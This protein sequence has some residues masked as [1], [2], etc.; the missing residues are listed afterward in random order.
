MSS[1]AARLGLYRVLEAAGVGEIRSQLSEGGKGLGV[2]TGL[3]GPARSLAEAVLAADEQTTVLLVVSDERRMSEVVSDLSTFLSSWDFQKEVLIFP[4]LQ[5]DPYRGLSPH[6]DIVTARARALSALV[7]GDPVV[8]VAPAAALLVRTALP[9]VFARGILNLERG[10]SFEPGEIERVL[11]EAGYQNEDPVMAPGDFAR[12]GMILDVHPPGFIEPLRLEFAGEELEEIRAFDPETQRTIATRDKA[13]IHPA[14]EWIFTEEHRRELMSELEGEKLEDELVARMDRESFPPGMGFALTRLPDFQANLFD[15]LGGGVVQVEE[16]ADIHR[17]GVSEWERALE[18]YGEASA[19]C[20]TACPEPRVL[21]ITPEELTSKL[22]ESG[23]ALEEMGLDEV[24][25]VDRPGRN[26]HISSQLLPTF[27]G[28]VGDF[29]EEVRRRVERERMQVHIFLGNRGLA[30]R[31][32]EILGEGNISAGLVADG[33]LPAG[34]VALHLGNLSHGFVLPG[35]R[36]VVFAAADVFAEPPRPERRRRTHKLGRFVSDFRDLKLGDYVVHVD[37]GVGVFT[38][39]QQM[40]LGTGSDEFV[41]LQ[42]LGGDKLYLPVEKLDLLEKFSSSETTRPRLDKLGGTGWGRVKQRVKKSMRDMTRELLR[43][44][45][46]RKAIA[47]YGFTSDSHW[48][49]EF[50]DLFEYQE[51]PDQEQAID[52]VKRDLEAPFPMDRLLCGDVGYGKTEVAMRAAFKVVM[53]NKQAAVLVPTT[54]LA[55]QHLSTFRARFAPYPVRVEMLSRFKSPKEQKAI[56]K[57]LAAAAVDIVIGTHRLLSKDVVFKDLGLLVIDEEQR[58]GVG[59]KERI[60]QLRRNVDCLTMSA[61]PIP[62]TLNMAFSG[63]RDLSVIETPPKDRLA[64]QTYITRLDRRVI[65][66]A[67]RYEL[68]RS[69]QVYFVHNRVG[70]IYS[71]ASFLKRLVPEARIEVGHGQMKESELERTML[72]FIR[73]EFDVLVSTTIIENGLD[74]P[75]VNTLFV[76]RADRFGLSELYQL[77]GRVG[78]SNRRA[79]AYLLVADEKTLTPIARRRLAA[80]REFSDLGAGFRIAALDLELRGAGNLLGG[81]QH[82]HIEAVGFDLYLKL[83]EDTV[84]ELTGEEEAEPIRP[85]MNLK[86]DLRICQPPSY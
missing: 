85:S 72:R 84:R 67:I 82:G 78:R 28:R 34:T 37:H 38:G 63:I 53:D 50:E 54:V 4:A 44:Y 39:L 48:Q 22:S 36:Q 77:R 58:F 12:R 41:V 5:V 74:I 76:N 65:A 8:I 52:E 66:E 57:D 7:E 81:E 11:L 56:V 3:M 19:R 13:R 64:I 69:G 45:A 15:Y 68:G 24:L 26:L 43:L 86:I 62:R 16:P 42:Y 70:S 71:M 49:G 80:I 10:C 73:H 32:V 21:L 17:R 27:Q 6:F 40:S 59:H 2:V 29:L 30:E 1:E 31:M 75:L 35:L 55:V 61:T 51:T 14:R 9:S 47:G 79:Y 23:V 25:A 60:K 20:K 18:S 46:A 83:L 33:P